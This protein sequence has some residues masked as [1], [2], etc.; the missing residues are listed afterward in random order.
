M[1]ES[2]LCNS[3]VKTRPD[4]YPRV[5]HGHLYLHRLTQSMKARQAAIAGR[6]GLLGQEMRVNEAVFGSI[7]PRLWLHQVTSSPL[8]GQ[9]IK[10]VI[11]HT[12]GW[13]LQD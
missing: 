13:I 9:R 1:Y 5:P 12:I 11:P 8:N 7:F 6:C 2:P 4:V 3:G 10:D